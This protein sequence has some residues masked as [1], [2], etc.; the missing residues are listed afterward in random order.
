MGLFNVNTKASICSFDS[1]SGVVDNTVKP[2]KTNGNS[3]YTVNDR[4]YNSAA[5]KINKKTK[6]IYLKNISYVFY[7]LIS[8]RFIELFNLM[9]KC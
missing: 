2:S 6:I 7:K 1:L 4:E 9:I 8:N 5:A 3:P